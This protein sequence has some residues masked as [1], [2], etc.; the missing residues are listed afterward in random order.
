MSPIMEHITK[1]VGGETHINDLSLNFAAGTFQV[2]LGRTLAGKT[3]LMRL[4]AGLDWPTS[5]RILAN[6]VDVTGVSVRKRNISMVYQQFINYPNLTVFENIASP[7]KLQKIDK[8]QIEGRVRATAV[9]LG[10][11]PYLQRYP[12]ELSGGQQ[13]RTAMARALVKEA[14]LILLDEPLVNLDYKLREELREE[15]REIFTLRKTLV[16]YATSEPSEALALGGMTTVLHEGRVVQQGPTP[17]VYQKPTTALAASLF[18]EPP[19]NLFSGQV[20]AD[21]VT[22]DNQVHFPLNSDLKHLPT[23]H[24]LFG[25]RPHH[26]SLQPVHPND[27]E[28]GV[29]V[30]LAEI[31]GSETFLHVKH[32]ETDMVL[33]L[34]GVHQFEVDASLPIYLPTHKLFVFTPDGDLIHIPRS[35]AQ[36]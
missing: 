26:L 23:G 32:R 21:E 12:L 1:V 16:I 11:E 25:I 30:D 20:A 28:L 29:T 6:G 31:S 9:K 27:L 18:S 35:A 7:L 5:G 17:Q 15:M 8:S 34:E 24:Y 2:L 4:I 36:G 3:T 13:Q 14:D 19:I 33:H 22:F 10:M